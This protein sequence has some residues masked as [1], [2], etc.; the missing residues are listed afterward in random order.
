MGPFELMDHLDAIPLITHVCE[1]MSHELGSR[2][3]P[4]V[5]LKNYEKAGRTG[6]SSG[7]GFYNYS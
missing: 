4:P 1:Y 6:K 3:R 7:K 2:F 5:W